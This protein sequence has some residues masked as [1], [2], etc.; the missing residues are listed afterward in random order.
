[1]GHEWHC[2]RSAEWLVKTDRNCYYGHGVQPPGQVV[3]LG[4]MRAQLGDPLKTHVDHN[5]IV[6][7]GYI[8]VLNWSLF[9]AEKIYIITET[10]V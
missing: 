10:P 2:G 5:N 6:A 1:M 9:Y 7:F 3:P 4:I 8:G